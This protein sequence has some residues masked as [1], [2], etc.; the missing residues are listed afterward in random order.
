METSGILSSSVNY[1]TLISGDDLSEP[2]VHGTGPIGEVAAA[3]NQNAAASI[4]TALPETA[5]PGQ[6][7]DTGSHPQRCPRFV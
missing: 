7:G 3:V 1:G 4:Y 5:A 6:C 2:S